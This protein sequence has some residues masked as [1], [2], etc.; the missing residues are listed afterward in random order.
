MISFYKIFTSLQLVD[1]WDQCFG[2]VV[3]S[4]PLRGMGAV[5]IRENNRLN[6]VSAQ[7]KSFSAFATKTLVY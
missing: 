5:T 7:P 3:S 1:F 6:Y 4:R 2:P